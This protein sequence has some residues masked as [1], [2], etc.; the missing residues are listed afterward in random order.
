[1]I[2][3]ALGGALT[4]R[5]MP[6]GSSAFAMLMAVLLAAALVGM[7]YSSPVSYTHHR[8]QRPDRIRLRP[9]RAGAD[10]LRQD[11]A[12]RQGYHLSLIHI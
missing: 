10:G 1:M 4:M 8:R 12:V 5:Y 2:M 3:G 9:Y 6:S 7:V 11:N